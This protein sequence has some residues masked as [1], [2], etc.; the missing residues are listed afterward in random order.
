VK[1]RDIIEGQLEVY[2][3]P[4]T[5][6]D[7][8]REIQARLVK[9]GFNPGN[10]D[11]IAG[12]RTLKALAE[13]KES[14]YLGQPAVVGPTTA[15]AL[16]EENHPIS[17]QRPASDQK[18][19]TPDTIANGKQFRLVNG[20]LVGEFDEIRTGSFLHWNEVFHGWT[21]IPARAEYIENTYRLADAFAWIRKRY[22][23]PIAITSGYRDE[24]TNR[25][26]GGSRFSQHLYCK[27]L[28]IC[29][30]N[31][32]SDDLK[33]IFLLARACPH[34]IGLGLGMCQGF[35]HIDIRDGGR[36]VFGYGC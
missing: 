33:E 32:K 13:F 19:L 20:E 27:G 24:D 5:A 30:L 7:L 34:V 21:R 15:R 26:V 25:Y 12:Q 29:P 28:D 6:T 35:V 9:L 18:L 36:T 1:L 2:V 23:K 17:E 10:I 14:R 22:N 11:G 16:L 4:T 31:G 8:I 3:N